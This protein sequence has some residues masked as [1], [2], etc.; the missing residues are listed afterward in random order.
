MAGAGPG[1]VGGA[2]FDTSRVGTAALQ[3]RHATL[4]ASPCQSAVE[5]DGGWFTPWASGGR[6]GRRGS[7]VRR[8]SR[9]RASL[10]QGMARGRPRTARVPVELLSN[11][12]IGGGMWQ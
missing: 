11:Q 6:R 12:S 9:K 1:E 7:N 8:G 2:A 5:T 10:A 3:A 4:L